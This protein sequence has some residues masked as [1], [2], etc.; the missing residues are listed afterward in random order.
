MEKSENRIYKTAADVH[1][2]QKEQEKLAVAIA[3]QMKVRQWAVENTVKIA[4]A[5][6]GHFISL[7]EAQKITQFFYDFVVKDDA[8]TE[9]KNQ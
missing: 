7:E 1:D 9:T 8:G 3:R 6:V 5:Q 4:V 2:A